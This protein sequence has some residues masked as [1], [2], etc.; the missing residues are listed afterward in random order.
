MARVRDIVKALETVAP[1]RYAFE[2]DKVG[3]Q[4]GDLDQT[5]DRAVVAMDPSLGAA[6]QAAATGAQLL[7]CHHPLIF[8]PMESVT[9]KNHQGKVVRKLIKADISYIAAHTNWD[10]AQGG[11]N[12]TLC[13]MFGVEETKPFGSGAKVSRLKMIVFCPTDQVE[14][15]VDAAA[16]AG[17]GVIGAYSRCFFAGSGAGSFESSS[18][19]SPAIGKSGERTSVEEVRVEMTLLESDR[20]AVERAVRS[21]HRYEEPAIDFVSLDPE[22]EQAAGRI[23]KLVKPETLA[24]LTSAVSKAVALPTWTWGDADRTISKVAVVGGAAD[25]EWKAAQ[26]AGADVLITGEVKQHIALEASENGFALIAAGHY[27]TEHPGCATLRDR[28]AAEVPNV[29]WDLFI[30]HAGFSGRPF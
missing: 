19:A 20:R 21:V 5:V 10:S 17:A 27:H 2:F 18:A 12:D 24:S 14:T 16:K 22:I 6:N 15:I 4:I 13:R 8:N 3:L 25:G 9:E 11:I 26:R 28:M 7:L 23:G 29:T 30:P 1:S